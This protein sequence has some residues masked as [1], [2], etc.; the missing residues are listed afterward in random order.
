MLAPL[1]QHIK[2]ISTKDV[3]VHKLVNGYECT[4]G[5]TNLV[6]RLENSSDVMKTKEMNLLSSIEATQ[7]RGNSCHR[8]EINE[9]GIKINIET[10]VDGMNTCDKNHK[11]ITHI[12]SKEKNDNTTML[13]ISGGLQVRFRPESD[14]EFLFNFS[15]EINGRKLHGS[16]AQRHWYS[17]YNNVN[18][19]ETLQE[20]DKKDF[21]GINVCPRDAY[22]A[23]FVHMKL[24]TLADIRRMQAIR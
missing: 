4:T 10:L 1:N 11:N 16:D 5:K 13:T 12:N 20:I 6:M 22:I 18:I 7:C 9:S 21:S 3:R 24:K 19:I 14:K 15:R 23:V 17:V 2:L 8:H